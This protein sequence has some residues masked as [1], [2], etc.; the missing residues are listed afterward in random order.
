MEEQIAY[1]DCLENGGWGDTMTLCRSKNKAFERC[2]IMQSRFLKALGYLSTY[3]RPPSV[4]EAIQMHADTLYHRMLAQEAAIAEAKTTG[5]PT[6]T[7]APILS[8]EKSLS[9]SQQQQ[10]ATPASSAA[11]AGD[12]EEA[13]VELSATTKALLRPESQGKLLKKLKELPAS[14]REV[15]E[16]SVQM[17][18][19]A[20]QEIGERVRQVEEGRKRRREEGN[21]SIGDTISGWFGW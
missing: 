15:E 4:D 14:E 8:P 20:S 16:R 10:A 18:A 19:R 7:F 13:E 21:A 17:E 6:P 2:Y 1:N 3:D 5:L 11:E 9:T 12:G